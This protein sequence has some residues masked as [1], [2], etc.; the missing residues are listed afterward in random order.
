[1]HSS[2]GFGLPRTNVSVIRYRTQNDYVLTIKEIKD[3]NKKKSEE[4]KNKSKEIVVKSF[5]RSENTETNN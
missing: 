2:S 1:M 4:R 5:G 3:E